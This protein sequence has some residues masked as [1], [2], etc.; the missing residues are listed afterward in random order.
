ME[1]ESE[2]QPLISSHP[3]AHDQAVPLSDSTN[4]QAIANAQSFSGSDK[5]QLSISVE[6]NMEHHHY[7]GIGRATSCI[8]FMA[9]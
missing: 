5:K 3:P 6:V 9:T 7:L 2:C 8:D 1:K 4:H